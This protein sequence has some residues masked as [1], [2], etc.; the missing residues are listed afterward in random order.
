MNDLHVGR[1]AFLTLGQ[2]AGFPAAPDA[3]QAIEPSGE[4]WERWALLSTPADRRRVASALCPR[5]TPHLIAT[6]A[7]RQRLSAWFVLDAIRHLPPPCRHYVV[8]HVWVVGLSRGFD[9]WMSQ[10]PPWPPPGGELQLIVVDGKT[11]EAPQLWDLLGHE[12]AHAWLCPT[13]AR[14]ARVQARRDH[15]ERV[16]TLAHEWNRPNPYVREAE[17]AERQAARLAGSWG[18]TGAGADA[19]FCA[20]GGARL[21][22]MPSRW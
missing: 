17:L 12:L 5:F 11:L 10:S 4:A 7:A 9:G 15:A 2:L 18:F 16:A 21:A 14:P 8:R 3:V 20:E 19:D 13:S 22:A 6:E 1:D